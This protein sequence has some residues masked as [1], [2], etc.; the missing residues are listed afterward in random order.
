M[1]RTH[2][3]PALISLVHLQHPRQHHWWLAEDGFPQ[4]IAGLL[5]APLRATCSPPSHFAEFRA[6]FDPLPRLAADAAGT[7]AQQAAYHYLIQARCRGATVSCWRRYPYGIG[8]VRR[9]GPMALTLF[10]HRFQGPP[11]EPC[12]RRPSLAILPTD[13]VV[14]Q[15]QQGGTALHPRVLQPPPNT[16]F[17]IAACG[18]EPGAIDHDTAEQ[19]H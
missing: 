15:N 18:G 2:P 10:V 16:S 9:C 5:G 11:V 7:A 1:S 17:T 8:W 19:Q 12:R 3:C 4:R 14:E 13:S 6:V